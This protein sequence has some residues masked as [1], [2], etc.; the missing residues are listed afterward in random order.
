[1]YINRQKPSEAI[2]HL[3]HGLQ[4]LVTL[5]VPPSLPR[6]LGETRIMPPRS[7]SGVVKSGVVK[8]G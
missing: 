7:F 2:I 8:G 4:L 1:M 6:L 5:V 3:L